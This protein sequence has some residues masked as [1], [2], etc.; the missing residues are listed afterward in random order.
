MNNKKTSSTQTLQTAL[1]FLTAIQ[2]DQLSAEDQTNLAEAL[3]ALALIGE[4]IVAEEQELSQFVSVVAHEMRIPM[5][6][7]MGYTDL[8][9]QGAMGEVNESQLSFLVIIR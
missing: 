9:K 2:A 7:I 3:Q 5:T 1:D 4:Q 6:S 8:L